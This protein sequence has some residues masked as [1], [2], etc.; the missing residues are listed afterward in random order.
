[1]SL[2]LKL[3]KP[4]MRK[5]IIMK[6]KIVAFLMLIC[7]PG[8]LLAES[9]VAEPPANEKN[10]VIKTAEKIEGIDATVSGVAV[11]TTIDLTQAAGTLEQTPATTSNAAASKATQYFIELAITEATIMAITADLEAGGGVANGTL[12]Q[13]IA[14]LQQKRDS[15]KD[16]SRRSQETQRNTSD[17]TD[18]NPINPDN[19]LKKYPDKELLDTSKK[20]EPPS[21]EFSYPESVDKTVDV[22][23]SPEEDG[24]KE[25]TFEED[26]IPQ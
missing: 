15:I 9:L 18:L 24:K 7:T 25:Y 14:D 26:P 10:S 2:C 6:Q 3:G 8:L 16:A 13:R 23:S 19:P 22:T 12:S 1:M 4:D 5:E 20:S 21:L 17:S 11:G